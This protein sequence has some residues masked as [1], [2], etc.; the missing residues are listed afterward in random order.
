MSSWS[1][2]TARRSKVRLSSSSVSC[3]RRAVSSICSTSRSIWA[4]FPSRIRATAGICSGGIDPS[5]IIELYP[6]TTVSGPRSS[7]DARFKKCAFVRSSSA[8]R[9]ACARRRAASRSRSASRAF[10]CRRRSV[11]SR[12]TF[13]KPRSLPDSSLSAVMTTFAQKRVPSLRRRQ[14]SS[15]YRPSRLATSSSQSGLRLLASSGG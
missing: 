6:R 15:S 8:M 11:R 1:W 14:P 2:A 7:C 13:P 4:S 9:S 10:S 12:V 5:C 3:S